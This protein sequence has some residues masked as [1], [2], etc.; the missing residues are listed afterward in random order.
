MGGS[1]DPEDGGFWRACGSVES[2]CAVVSLTHRSVTKDRVFPAQIEDVKAGVRFLRAHAEEYG[3]DPN[4]I[5][6][7]GASS[8]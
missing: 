5:A 7:M 3:L 2:S 6:A 4:R 8:G 1:G